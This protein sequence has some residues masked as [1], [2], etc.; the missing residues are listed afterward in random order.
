MVSKNLSVGLWSTL[1]PIIRGLRS[2]MPFPGYQNFPTKI[3]EKY[4]TSVWNTGE[5]GDINSS[6]N[7]RDM[8]TSFVELGGGVDAA[9][10]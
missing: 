9:L 7:I 5:T 10:V 2:R 3:Q 4:A 1:T 8:F 6:I